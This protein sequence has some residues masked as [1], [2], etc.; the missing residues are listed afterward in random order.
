MHW[1]FD[2]L[3]ISFVFLF[4]E[5]IA[6]PLTHYF[7]NQKI[8]QYG[9][10]VFD[11]LDKNMPELLLQ[12]NGQ[13]LT[14]IVKHKLHDVSGQTVTTKDLERLFELYDPRLTADLHNS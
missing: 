8:R 12:Y 6:K 5:G 14:E 13:Q 10:A 4:I 3:S 7:F 11:F 9:P 1:L 2:F